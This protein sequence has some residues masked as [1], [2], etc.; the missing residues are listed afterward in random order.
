MFFS[1]K[2]QEADANVTTERLNLHPITHIANCLLGYQKKLSTNEVA[3]LD[4][5]QAISSSFQLVLEEN[6][7]LRE[8]LDSFHDLFTDVDTASGNF[9]NVKSDIAASVSLSQ[10]RVDGLKDSSEEVQNRFE[11]MQE[12]FKDFQVSVQKIK[13]CMAQIISIPTKPICWP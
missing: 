2:S 13:D 4:E 9:A 7:A 11:E 10:K 1:K 3:S 12:T 8:K 5:L 6:A